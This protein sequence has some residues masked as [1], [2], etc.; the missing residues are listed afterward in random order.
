MVQTEVKKVGCSFCASSCGML[1]HIEDG[2]V[3]K[4]EP[5]LEHRLSRGFSCE[6][7]KY[8]IKWLQHPDQLKYPLKRQGERGEGKWQRVTWEQAL[9][10]IAG[11]LNELKAEYGPETLA[12]IE[13]TYR[14]ENLWTRSRFCNLFGNPQNVFHPGVICGLN[15]LAIGQAMMGDSVFGG[16]DIARTNCLVLTGMRPYESSQRTI[17]SIIRRKSKGPMKLIVIDPMTTRIAREA[18]IHLQLRPGTDAALFMGWI[19]VIINEGLYD[20]GFVEKWTTGFDQMAERAREYSPDKVAQI[21][22]IPADRI[23]ESARLYATTKPA[24][25][26]RGVASDQIGATGSTRAA[27]ARNVLRAITGNL[28]IPGGELIPG[29]GPI[30]DG[31][32][33][34]RDAEMELADRLPDDMK[35]KQLGWEKAPLMTWLGYEMVNRKWQQLHGVPLPTMHR[36][37]GFVPWLWQAILKGEPYPIKAAI[38]WGA[39]P[40][41]WAPNTKRVYQALKSPNL[42][43]H[44]VQEFWMTPCA[45]LADYVLPAAS[46]LER[47]MCSTTEDF[48]DVIFGGV[49]AVQPLGERKDDY[50]FW[51]GLGLAVGQDKRDWPWEN[52]E[53]VIAYRLKPLGITY[54]EFAETGYVLGARKY[55]KYEEEGFATAS[56]KVELASSVFEKLGQD[57]LPY[58]QE[59]PETPVSAPEVVKEYPLILTTGGRFMPMYHSEHRQMGIG[60]REKHPDPLITIHP[61]TAKG[62]SINDGDWVWIETRRGRIKQKAHLDVGTLP[63]VVNCE[64]SWWFPEKPGEEP[65]VFGLWESNANVLTPDDEEFCDP[66]T[67]G[68]ANRALLCKIYPVE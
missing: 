31:K 45:Q 61:Q 19:N 35:K 13:G 36:L 17:A 26:F 14:G 56:G 32:R 41:M 22:G 7:I 60:M 52:L 6:R 68:W 50:T 63:N 58:Y 66:L 2:K 28:D 67:G 33:F 51:R 20:R 11:K 40:L 9:E 21:V 29:V 24:S 65:S 15:C 8:A 46:W 48:T 30:I 42:E 57:P 18:D 37:G 38:T 1:V 44:V 39:N 43:L 64:A 27:Q 5:N 10:E 49:R 47:P 12:V 55:R 54:E 3:V 62:L 23:I 53:E 4:I 34:I 59:Q 25:L 16:P